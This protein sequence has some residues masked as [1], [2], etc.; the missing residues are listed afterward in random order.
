MTLRKGD[1]GEKVILLQAALQAVGVGLPRYGVD[2]IFGP[3]TEGA[4]KQ[5][6]QMFG[7]TPTGVADEGLLRELNVG[8]VAKAG[9]VATSKGGVW[10]AI[11]L[12][13]GVIGWAV[14]K[15]MEDS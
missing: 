4:V 9:R 13:V 8:D 12:A 2:G 6:Q 5:A 7:M 1:R 11:G 15:H 14:K 3:E 10:V